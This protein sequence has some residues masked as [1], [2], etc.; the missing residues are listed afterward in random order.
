M[1]SDRDG[2]VI[3][4]EEA[5][6]RVVM[7]ER[8]TREQ[9]I[10]VSKLPKHYLKNPKFYQTTSICTVINKLHIRTHKNSFLKLNKRLCLKPTCVYVN[11]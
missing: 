4:L 6:D 8:Q 5:N 9:E 11:L 3:A 7:L 1:Q 10:Q 2:L